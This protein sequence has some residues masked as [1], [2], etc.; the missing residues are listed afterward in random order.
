M[1]SSIIDTSPFIAMHSSIKSVKGH[2]AHH[3]VV[4]RLVSFEK[5]RK[6]E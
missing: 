4:K 5:E 3:F 2:Q 6:R 1:K